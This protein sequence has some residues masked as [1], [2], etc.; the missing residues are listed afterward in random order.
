MSPV[1]G[2]F[3][4]ISRLRDEAGVETD[5]VAD[6]VELTLRPARSDLDVG[7]ATARIDPSPGS[8]LELNGGIK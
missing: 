5:V 3:C 1:A 6:A 2:V 7:S 8:K 4:P